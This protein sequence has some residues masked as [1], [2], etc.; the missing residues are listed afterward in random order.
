MFATYSN[1]DF[2]I[3]TTGIELRLR[4]P[5]I[6]A[7]VT[8]KGLIFSVDFPFSLFHNN[9]E[10]QCGKLHS[11]ITTTAFKQQHIKRKY[12]CFCKTGLFFDKPFLSKGFCDNNKQNDCRLPNGEVHPSCFQ[13]ANKWKVED[14]SKPYCENP[15]PPNPSPGPTP[16]TAPCKPDICEILLSE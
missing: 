2:I 4:I 1:D 12:Q 3:T 9:T 6:E 7:I 15:P 5:A 13:M 8:F 11:F 10:G 16:T 14:K